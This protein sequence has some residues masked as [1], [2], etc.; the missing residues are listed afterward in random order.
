MAKPCG[1]RLVGGEVDRERRDGLA[2]LGAEGLF[3]I[4]TLYYGA[5]RSN[6]MRVML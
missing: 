4:T 1:V 2:P 5:K 3:N 6:I